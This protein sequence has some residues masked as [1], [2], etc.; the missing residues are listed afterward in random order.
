MKSPTQ[1]LANDPEVRRHFR[2]RLVD[3]RAIALADSEAAE[4]VIFAIEHLG[5]FIAQ[6]DKSLES[7]TKPLLKWVGSAL[8]SRKP[9][10]DRRLQLLRRGRNERMHRGFAAR[11]L[12]A[13]AVRVALILEDALRVE[14]EKLTAEDLMTPNPLEAKPWHSFGMVRDAMI[15][16]SFSHV[17]IWWKDEWRLISERTMCRLVQRARVEKCDLRSE[18]LDAGVA[19]G[20]TEEVIADALTGRTTTTVAP[21]TAA[22]ALELGTGCLL[23]VR[24]GNGAP[25]LIGII[26]AADVI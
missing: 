13:D 7:L 15:A 10:L 2:R 23:V 21:D 18:R 9:E 12:T 22:T 1:Q 16:N 4:A 5:R 25:E 6:K 17:P 19:L 24:G 20:G 26:T 14:W 11:D 8:P 3:A